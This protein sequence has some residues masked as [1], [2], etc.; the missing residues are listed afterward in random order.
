MEPWCTLAKVLR[1]GGEPMLTHVLRQFAPQ[2]DAV[3]ISANAATAAFAN[4]GAAFGAAVVA[5]PLPGFVGH[6]VGVLAAMEWAAAHAPRIDLVASVA[7]DTPFLPLDLVECLAD[8]LRCE[9]ADVALAASHGRDHPVM[10]VWRVIL[11]PRL[12]SHLQSNADRSVRGFQAALRAVIVRFDGAPDP[13]LNVNS[14]EDLVRAHAH[15]PAWPA[16]A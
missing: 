3:V 2:A 1:L 4:L 16:A 7:G 10:A 5:D 15:Q 6:L 14:P 12:R 11:A 9:D 8:A 13:F